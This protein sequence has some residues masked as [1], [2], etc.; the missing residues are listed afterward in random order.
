[1]I[2][3]STME[4]KWFWQSISPFQFHFQYFQF[5]AQFKYST[6]LRPNLVLIFFFTK[7]IYVFERQREEE[8]DRA[9]IYLFPPQMSARAKTGLLP[10]LAARCSGQ[11]SC[12]SGTQVLVPLPDTSQVLVHRKLESGPGARSW[13]QAL[14]WR[15]WHLNHWARYPLLVLIFCFGNV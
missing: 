5:L 7:F 12:M 10:K 13:T 11:V 14:P 1:M 8:A 6:V 2:V 4:N 3:I 15:M 9:S